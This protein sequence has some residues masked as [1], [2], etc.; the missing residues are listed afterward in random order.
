MMQEFLH[1]CASPI[2]REISV[3]FTQLSTASMIYLK[4][5]IE[6]MGFHFYCTEKIG[7]T[8]CIYSYK[9]LA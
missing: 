8:I 5:R 4:I 1:M 3:K 9:A 2:T 6:C 7:Y